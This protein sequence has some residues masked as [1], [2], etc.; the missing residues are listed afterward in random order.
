MGKVL[1]LNASYEPLNITS[2]RRAVVLLLKGKAE[3]VEHNGRVVYRNI[4]L[5]TVIRLRHYIKVPYKEIPLTRK[6]ILHR[7]SHSCQYCGY[8][9]DDLTLDHV[10]PRSRGGGEHW[11]NMVTACV[12]CNIRKGNRTPKEANM[13]LRQPPRRPH[14]SLYFEVTKHVKSGVHQEWR[15]YVIGL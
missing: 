3:Q 10:V 15:K 9:G 2:W 7:D 4:P 13:P 8:T 6:N 11:E 14:S 12:R 1:V 5:P